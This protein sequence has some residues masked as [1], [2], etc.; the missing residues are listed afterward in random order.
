MT[1]RSKYV[2]KKPDAHGYINY[3]KEENAIWNELFTRQ[4]RIIIDRACDEFIHGIQAL[5]MASSHIPQCPEIKKALQHS[6]GWQVKPVEAIIPAEEFFS[7]LAECKFP[8]AAFIRRREELDYLQEPDIFHEIFGHC[9]M[10]TDHNYATFMQNYGNLALAANDIDRSYLARLYWFTIEFGLIH[11]ANG[12]RIYG[13]G[14]L[15]SMQETIYAIESPIPVRLPLED[16]LTAL[17]TPYRIDIL[18]PVYFFIQSYKDL[19]HIMQN[20]IM[21]LIHQAQ[22]LGDLPPRFD[23]EGAQSY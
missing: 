10:L 19:Y 13:G 2:A 11:T 8:A 22:D 20:D 7:L 3:T 23:L 18:Q 6:T 15:S 4:S 14:I 5:H 12:M 9:P 17:R 21:G 16:G 1:F